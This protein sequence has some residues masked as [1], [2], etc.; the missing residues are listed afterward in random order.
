[1][2]LGAGGCLSRSS[3]NHAKYFFFQ[4]PSCARDLNFPDEYS[5]FWLSRLPLS[6]WRWC[7][8]LGWDW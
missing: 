1:L 8:F 4:F 7:C 3:S 6:V 5:R 2:Q